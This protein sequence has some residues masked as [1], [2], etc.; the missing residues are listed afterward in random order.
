[1][2]ESLDDLDAEV[3]VVTAGAWVRRLIPDLPVRPT[4]ETLAYFRREGVAVPSIGQL[5]PETRGHV[6]YSLHD[7]CYGLKSGVHHAGRAIDPD[8]SGDPDP[9]LLKQTAAW[10]AHT[11]PDTHPE[12][13]DAETRLYTQQAY[14]PLS[15]QRRRQV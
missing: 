11:H 2:V 9:E 6:Q 7:P 1:R 12:P 13:A 14:E 10:V 8:E 15:P 3:V 4:R 5:D